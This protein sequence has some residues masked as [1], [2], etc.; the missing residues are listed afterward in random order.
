MNMTGI[1]TLFILAQYTCP[2]LWACALVPTY[3]ATNKRRGTRTR[4]VEGRIL[5]LETS[6]LIYEDLL[7]CVLDNVALV[8][9][10]EDP[11]R[12]TKE[13]SLLVH[14]GSAQSGKEGE[15]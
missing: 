15:G 8:D 6:L 7:V 2:I 5:G 4:T 9:D 12:G 10:G 1:R 13:S 3:T 11:G 14:V